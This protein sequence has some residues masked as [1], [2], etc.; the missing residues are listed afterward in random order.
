MGRVD[1]IRAGA[2][3]SKSL[4]PAQ[5]FSTFSVDTKKVYTVLTCRPPIVH[6]MPLSS[7]RARILQACCSRAFVPVKKL[8]VWRG[9][10]NKA[11]LL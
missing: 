2:A 6:N 1:R 10:V 8:Y 9:Y 11:F 7:A 4:S 3:E 5:K